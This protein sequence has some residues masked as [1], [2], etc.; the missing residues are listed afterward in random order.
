MTVVRKKKKSRGEIYGKEEKANFISEFC[1]QA[2][3]QS[4]Y[5]ATGISPWLW[6][7]LSTFPV[8]AAEPGGL[9]VSGVTYTGNT[10]AFPSATE[11][12]AG[13]EV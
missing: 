5:L 1:L 10:P 12:E 8:P 3:K 13:T 7:R 4:C 2:D 9:H 6:W 11:P